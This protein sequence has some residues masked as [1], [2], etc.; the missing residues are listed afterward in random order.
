MSTMI[1]D[2]VVGA[3]GLG[4][5]FDSSA[6]LEFMRDAD[7]RHTAEITDLQAENRQ[8]IKRVNRLRRVLERCAALSEEVSNEKHKVLLEASQPL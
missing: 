6:E 5:N 4:H 3:L 1:P 2:L 8:L 7:R